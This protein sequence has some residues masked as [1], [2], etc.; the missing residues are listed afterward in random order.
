LNI[1]GSAG[2]VLFLEGQL[3]E[4]EN[5]ASGAAK[6]LAMNVPLRRGCC[7]RLS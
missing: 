2:H 5:A 7:G 6:E 4:W 3:A 1:G